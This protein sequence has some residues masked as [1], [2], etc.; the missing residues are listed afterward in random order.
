[1]SFYF[2][3]NNLSFAFGMIGAIIL[4][5]AAWLSFDAYLLQKDSAVLFRSAGLILFATWKVINSLNS[6]NDVLS[7]I[8][9]ILFLVGLLLLIVSFFRDKETC[10]ERSHC[11][12]CFFFVVKPSIHHFQYFCLASPIFPCGS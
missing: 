6:S 4:L 5:I 8:G 9:F 10:N 7:Y 2:L 3:I 1:M 12:P 11:N